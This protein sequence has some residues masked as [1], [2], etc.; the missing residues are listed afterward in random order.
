MAGERC[1]SCLFWLFVLAIAAYA[2]FDTIVE[3]A[4]EVLSFGIVG[5]FLLI[6]IGLVVFFFILKIIIKIFDRFF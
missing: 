1:G 5:I 6:V 4:G 2:L 3:E